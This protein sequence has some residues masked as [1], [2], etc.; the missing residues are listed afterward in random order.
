MDI[1]LTKSLCL[2]V[3]KVCCA[4][5]EA[6]MDERELQSDKVEDSR[7]NVEDLLAQLQQLGSS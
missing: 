6:S 1:A 4:C 2:P 7:D 5:Q 3:L